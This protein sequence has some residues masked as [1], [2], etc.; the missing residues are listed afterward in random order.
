MGRYSWSDRSTVEDSKVLDIFWLRQND[1]FCGFRSGTIKWSRG[2][3][4]TGTIGIQ[5]EVRN[6]PEPGGSVRLYYTSTSHG[7]GETTNL[8]YRVSLNTT[9]CNYGKYRWWFECPLY[10][11][12]KRVGKLYLPPGAKYF[13]CRNCHR[14]TYES[15]RES[16]GWAYRFAKSNGF[17]MGQMKRSLRE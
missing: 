6:D 4:V 15:C 2:D 9:W 8:D 17:T 5:V 12:G 11:C 7:T 1:Y 16:H 3:N 14:L 13:G 10:G